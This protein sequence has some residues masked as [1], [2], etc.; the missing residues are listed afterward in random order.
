MSYYRASGR[1]H[2]SGLVRLASLV[3]PG[4]AVGGLYGVVAFI[5]LLVGDLV[6][7]VVPL[8]HFLSDSSWMFAAFLVGFVVLAQV[9]LVRPRL[10]AAH[11]RS[12]LVAAGAGLLIGAVSAVTK[13]VVQGLGMVALFEMDVP[14]IAVFDPSMANAFV[15]AA[16]DWTWDQP[17]E[18]AGVLVG[19]LWQGEMVLMVMAPA[20][21]LYLDRPTPYCE[22]CGRWVPAAEAALVVD[23]RGSSNIQRLVQDWDVEALA[24]LPPPDYD[25]FDQQQA[26]LARNQNSSKQSLRESDQ[27][28]HALVPYACKVCDDFTAIEVQRL[29][30]TFDPETGRWRVSRQPV[31]PRTMISRSQLEALD[32]AIQ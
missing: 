14:W 10:V 28:C 6:A 17:T 12:S 15:A 9:R 5:C 4:I 30:R 1:I 23:L 26:E 27:L 18:H 32:E 8:P 3:V 22:R 19:R 24:A 16:V 25:R 21:L 2:P 13:W 7:E 20:V 11:S 29:A 31:G